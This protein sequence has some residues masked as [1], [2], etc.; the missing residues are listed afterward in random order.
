MAMVTTKRLKTSIF[1]NKLKNEVTAI[2][3]PSGCGKST[4]I[5]TLNRMIEKYPW[6]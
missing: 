1:K 5:K 6:R 2:I 4:F 3:G